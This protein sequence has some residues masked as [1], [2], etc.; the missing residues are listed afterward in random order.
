MNA[1]AA[2]AVDL[3]VEVSV[4]CQLLEERV[5]YSPTILGEHMALQVIDY[6]RDQQLGYFPPFDYLENNPSIDPDLLIL[7]QELAS[8]SSHY[9]KRTTRQSLSAEFASVRVRNVFSP[10]FAMPK[11]RVHAA[12]AVAELSQHYSPNQVRVE[13][14]LISMNEVRLGSVEIEQNCKECARQA[15]KPHFERVQIAYAHLNAE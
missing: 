14:I 8:F 9:A 1:P 15:L 7:M 2:V 3:A 10:F 11:I 6:V 5:G 12:N 13:V 4:P